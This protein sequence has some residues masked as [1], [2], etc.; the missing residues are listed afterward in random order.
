MPDNDLSALLADTLDAITGLDAAAVA[1]A[2]ARQD[3]LTKP[4]GSLGV[5][6]D[7][8][9][10]LAGLASLPRAAFP[11]QRASPSS[12]P[13]TACTPRASPRGRRRSPPRWSP[14]SSP[15]AP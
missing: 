4:R 9:V 5:L 14:T 6:E 13:I 8:S 10:Q 11:N 7:V 3:L 2:R 12:P 1:A 15:G